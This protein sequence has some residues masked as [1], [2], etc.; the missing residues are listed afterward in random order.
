MAFLCR[1]KL[2]GSHQFCGHDH[3]ADAPCGAFEYVRVERPEDLPPTDPRIVDV[4]VLDMNHGWPNLGHDCIV[5]ALLDD[6]CELLPIAAETGVRVRA[7]SFDVRRCGMIP[8]PPGGR[9]SIYLGTGGPG[10]IDPYANDGVS[11]ES[12]GITEDPSWQAP[13]FRLFDAILDDP[14]AALLAVCHT[15]GVMCH[16]SGIAR[17]VLRGPEK[18]GKS[19][20][21]LENV[22][23]PEACGHPWFR[24]FG[25]E[26][27]GGRLRV[28]DNRLFDLIPP[29]HTLPAGVLPV[30]WETLGVGGPPGDAVTM[31]EFARDGGGVMPR[32]FG[33]NHHPEIIVNREGQIA[34]LEQKVERGEVTAQWAAERREILFHDDPDE[35]SERLLQ[36]TSDF[37]LLRP[38]RFHLQRQVR[39][40]AESLG[41]TVDLDEERTALASSPPPDAPPR[42]P[43]LEVR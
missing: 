8:E 26:L 2:P 16:W 42:L 25:D 4:A 12:Q 5:H 1:H 20:G 10:H 22:L 30:G 17:P 28:M 33:V 38:L 11:P 35:D 31:I 19:T 39:R 29:G 21:V 37:T 6:A 34:I 9:F 41:F 40:R 23:D 24:R 3:P 32:V 36:L 14:E 43:I 18:G 7:L 27:G 13:L 15:F